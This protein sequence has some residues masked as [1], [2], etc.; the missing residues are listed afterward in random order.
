MLAPGRLWRVHD[1]LLGLHAS[2][3]AADQ[4]LAVLGPADLL[5]PMLPTPVQVL[6]PLTLYSRPWPPLPEDLSPGWWQAPARG[7]QGL[8][9][10]AAQWAYC[11]HHHSPVA[12]SA[13]W[14]LLALACA[15]QVSAWPAEE[16]PPACE[17]SLQPPRLR[18]QLSVAGG[19]PWQV[20]AL[21]QALGH[22]PTV[23]EK[24][25][26]V[27]VRA[28]AWLDWPS[29]TAPLGGAHHEAD[30]SHQAR[31]GHPSHLVFGHGEAL[32]TLACDCHR[33]LIE[34]LQASATASATLMP[35][36]PAESMPP[37]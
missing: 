17:E 33:P 31:D 19:M 30:A 3:A 25:L 15:R 11:S 16:L 12:R 28:G 2:G 36:T 24:V 21:Q 23:F 1:G 18:P 10:Q 22:S 7:L 34:A 37:A 9:C 5:A 20:S 8:Q 26:Q 13:S 32:L 6:Q 14:S 4:P 35:S 29:H 27:M